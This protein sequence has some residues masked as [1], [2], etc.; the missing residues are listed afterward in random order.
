M[1]S[2]GI[3]GIDRSAVVDAEAGVSPRE[4][5]VD[6]FLGEELAVPKQAE[7]LVSEEELGLVGVDVGNGM[8]LLMAIPDSSGDR[9]S[10]SW[11]ICFSSVRSATT[12][13]TL[14]FSSSRAFSLFASLTSSPPYLRRHV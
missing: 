11:S 8:P 3:G 7:Q 9:D 14:E 1:Q 4:Q 2:L 10:T 12:R 5:K 6:A 13:L